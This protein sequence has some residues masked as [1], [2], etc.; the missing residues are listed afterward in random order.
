MYAGNDN[1][2]ADVAQ[3]RNPDKYNKNAERNRSRAVELER[4]NIYQGAVQQA[5]RLA[6]IHDPSGVSFN[7]CPVVKLDDGTVIPQE[8]FKRREERQAERAA[9]EESKKDGAVLE[10]T[11]TIKDEATKAAAISERPNLLQEGG[12]TESLVR[13][14]LAPGKTVPREISKKQQ[15]KIALYTPRPPPPKPI[16]PDGISIPEGEEDWLSLWDLPSDQVERRV[17]R[18]KKHKAA[19]RKAL[20]VRQQSGKAE[21][22]AARDEKRR[23]YREIKLEWKAIKGKMV[24]TLTTGR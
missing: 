3:T 1:T 21:R 10:H 4:R 14:P 13:H 2:Q 22:R 17:L 23:V 9:L 16:I 11:V 15:K 5:Q 8:L 24:L 19:E 20:R 18:E 6:A 7:V 12:P